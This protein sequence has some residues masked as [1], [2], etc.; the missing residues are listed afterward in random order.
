[1]KISQSHLWFVIFFDDCLVFYEKLLWVCLDIWSCAFHCYENQVKWFHLPEVW[2]I[3]LWE[4]SS[5]LMKIRSWWNGSNIIKH[6][7]S[8]RFK[9]AV[10]KFLLYGVIRFIEIGRKTSIIYC[11][12]VNLIFVFLN[13]LGWEFLFVHSLK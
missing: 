6:C 12:K 4:C 7:W 2:I 3:L 5:V 8:E 9:W 11:F 13:W 10:I 1:L